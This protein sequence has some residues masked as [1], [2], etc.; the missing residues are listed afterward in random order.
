MNNDTLFIVIF[1][2]FTKLIIG[3][4]NVK[5]GSNTEFEVIDLESET[6]I[7]EN[8]A[9]FPITDDSTVGGLGLDNRCQFHQHFWSSF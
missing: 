6:N 5:V 3:L 7:C 9:P 1:L 8:L 2:G 4:G